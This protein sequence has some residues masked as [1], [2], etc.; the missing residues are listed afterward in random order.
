MSLLGCSENQNLT[1]TCQRLF[2]MEYGAYEQMYRPDDKR[3][4][5]PMNS[6]NTRGVTVPYGR[7]GIWGRFCCFL[8]DSEAKRKGNSLDL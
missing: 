8:S 7:E 1:K 2:F 4:P 6:R 5:P 3:L